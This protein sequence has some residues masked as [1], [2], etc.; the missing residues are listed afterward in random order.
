M[1]GFHLRCIIKFRVITLTYDYVPPLLK[2]PSSQFFVFRR[3]IYSLVITST[4]EN[5]LSRLFVFCSRIRSNIQKT[6]SSYEVI[7]SVL[8]STGYMVSMTSAV[9]VSVSSFGRHSAT[10]S[11][12]YLAQLWLTIKSS[13]CMGVLVLNWARWN[14]SLIL[15][16]RVMFRT[17]A[18][19]VTFSGLTRILPYP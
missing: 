18:S 13:A 16:G 4:E 9:A 6:S 15:P 19:S 10:P 7:T 14:R 12:A 11:I 5:S 1:A 3:I 2:A 8:G 17:P